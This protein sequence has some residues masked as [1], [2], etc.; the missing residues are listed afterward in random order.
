MAR[1]LANNAFEIILLFNLAKV[2][3][4]QGQLMMIHHDFIDLQP[5]LDQKTKM[6]TKKKLIYQ[7]RSLLTLREGLKS[8][9]KISTFDYP[10]LK[11]I[12]IHRNLKQYTKYGP[13]VATGRA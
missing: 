9:L 12:N 11:T 2:H 5:F 8:D 13:F 7:N 10:L 4:D 6:S 1:L 3:F